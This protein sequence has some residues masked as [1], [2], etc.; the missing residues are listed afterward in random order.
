MLLFKYF[1]CHLKKVGPLVSLSQTSHLST[2]W[3]ISAFLCSTLISSRR[4]LP[5]AWCLTVLRTMVAWLPRISKCSARLLNHLLISTI[6]PPRIWMLTCNPWTTAS[7]S[8]QSLNWRILRNNHHRD[9]KE[10]LVKSKGVQ[11]QAFQCFTRTHSNNFN[12]P[13]T[14]KR[15]KKLKSSSNRHRK[16]R[17]NVEYT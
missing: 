9:F 8:V 10:W 6:T 16:M 17:A 7:L 3:V 4:I 14:C 15:R 13:S 1:Q 11:T 2:W 12:S 5:L